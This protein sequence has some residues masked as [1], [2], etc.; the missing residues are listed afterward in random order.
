MKRQQL[1]L[2]AGGAAVIAAVAM[3]ACGSSTSPAGTTTPSRP[4]SAPAART[5]AAAV[6]SADVAFTAGMLRLEGQSTAMAA[7]VAGH[8]AT[9]QLRQFAARL[10]QHDSDTRHM[11]DLMGDWHQPAPAP[12][13]PGAALPGGMG[14]GMMGVHDWDEMS[15][16]H[17]QGFNDHWLDAMIASHA[18]E[19][20][21]CRD[22]L[23]SGASPQARALAR[24]M[25]AQRQAELS[26]LRRWHH[27]H[28][29]IG[30]HD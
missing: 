24:A 9:A 25:L 4:A 22:E 13:A 26:Q 12:Y 10:R 1:R 5:P 7:L 18:A 11:R 2:A 21:L 23:R 19:I 29:H 6:N 14:P 28:E 3:A 17:G 8:T 30:E 27:D 15:H 16:E 20:T